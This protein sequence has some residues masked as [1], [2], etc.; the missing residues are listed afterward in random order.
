MSDNDIGNSNDHL[1]DHES[2]TV[3][4]TDTSLPVRRRGRP[5]GST[6]KPK[7]ISAVKPPMS[8]T[9]D[10]DLNKQ[11]QKVLLKKRIKK[12]VAKYIDKYQRPPLTYNQAMYPQSYYQ[13]YDEEEEQEDK[14]PQAE[15]EEEEES[16]DEGYAENNDPRPS[17]SSFRRHSYQPP[18]ASEKRPNKYRS[19][20]LR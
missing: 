2:N 5:K 19:A 8:V 18:P 11:M 1:A 7:D 15:E 17:S 9:F 16:E 10:E 13:P 20:L 14:A 3:G 4:H 6:N 12:Y